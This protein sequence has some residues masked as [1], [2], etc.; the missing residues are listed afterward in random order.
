MKIIGIDTSCYTTSVCAVDADE[1][2]LGDYRK[3]L[4]VKQG[5]RGLRQSEAV[6]QHMNNL[7]YLISKQFS[8]Q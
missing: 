1:K 7:P 8:M 4:Q 5:N 6:F 2:L 3:V